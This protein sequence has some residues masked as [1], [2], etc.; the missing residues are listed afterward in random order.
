[1]PLRKFTAL[2]ARTVACFLANDEDPEKALCPHEPA[3][4]HKTQATTEDLSHHQ[5]RKPTVRS[6]S[7]EKD[8][9][10]SSLSKAGLTTSVTHPEFA[11]RGEKAVGQVG[12]SGEGIIIHKTKL[13]GSALQESRHG[14]KDEEVS[15]EKREKDTKSFTQNLFDTLAVRML[16]WLPV[17]SLMTIPDFNVEQQ[18]NGDPS[19]AA[20]PAEV[21]PKTKMTEQGDKSDTYKPRGTDDLDLKPKPRSHSVTTRLRL[22]SDSIPHLASLPG[23]RRVSKQRALSVNDE[24]KQDSQQQSRQE[25]LRHQQGPRDKAA[26]LSAYAKS[27]D[28]AE[29]T[30]DHLEPQAE[31]AYGQCSTVS[32]LPGSAKTWGQLKAWVTQNQDSAHACCEDDGGASQKVQDL[33]EPILQQS[34]PINSSSG[35]S[36]FFNADPDPTLIF[37]IPVGQTLATELRTVSLSM[38]NGHAHACLRA[39]AATGTEAPRTD[40]LGGPESSGSSIASLPP[41]GSVIHRPD[42]SKR[43]ILTRDKDQCLSDQRAVSVKPPVG[44]N[45]ERLPQSLSHLSVEIV[46][47]LLVLVKPPDSLAEDPLLFYRL[48][49]FGSGRNSRS[50]ILRRH[51]RALQFGAQS[52]FYVFSNPEALLQSFRL[53]LQETAVSDNGTVSVHNVHPLQI[54]QAIRLLKAFDESKIIFRSLWI[55]LGALFTPSPDLSHPKSPRLKA[56]ISCSKTR[57]SLSS[58]ESGAITPVSTTPYYSDS[59]AVHIMTL[60]LAALV[61]AVPQASAQTMLAVRKLRA[62]GR[63]APDANV[64]ATNAERIKSLLEVTDALEDDLA[65][66]LMSRLTQAI[67]ARCCAA[68]IIKNKQ[69]R[70]SSY[71]GQDGHSPDL[72]QLLREYLKQSRC[73][74]HTTKS[75]EAGSSSRLAYGWSMPAIA[76]EWLRSVLLKE[77]NGRAEVQRWGA[78]GGAVMILAS[79]CMLRFVFGTALSIA[80]VVGRCAARGAWLKP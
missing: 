78:V 6:T 34:D 10:N 17:P 62:S 61:A 64:L 18:E 38:R 26:Q 58:S 35:A 71:T 53:P 40:P 49:G 44:P 80:N 5:Q 70:T 4:A 43:L 79:L 48:S 9:T 8:R 65:L 45:A 75:E 50:S 42:L 77:W 22:N 52:V 19:A 76:V 7:R 32:G 27:F 28:L 31:I 46:E 63:V 56:A 13:D 33:S 73:E 47:A 69:K 36:E 51:R 21:N 60:C 14:D 25:I 41:K 29:E 23:A 24:I 55:A 72:L 68:E 30:I 16:E 74:N 59:K 15:A 66:R 37:D 1:M 3:V 57:S 2:S 20:S 39:P 67:A 11:G 54:D 12:K